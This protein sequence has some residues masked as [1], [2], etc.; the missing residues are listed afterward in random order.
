VVSVSALDAQSAW[1]VYTATSVPLMSARCI[2][3][4]AILL[5]ITALA[6][7]S[8]CTTASGAI[9]LAPTSVE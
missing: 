1:G 7:I 5:L 8:L 3:A 6:A 2:V 4:S 9:S